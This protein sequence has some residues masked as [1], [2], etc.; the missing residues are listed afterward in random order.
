MVF[1]MWEM[2]LSSPA[3]IAI[4]G[5]AA[6]GGKSFALLMEPLRHVAKTGFSAVIFR[7]TSKQVKNEGGLWDASS[8][9]Y[10]AIGGK[11]KESELSWQDLEVG[12]IVQN[13][14][15]Y[16][17]S[18][19]LATVVRGMIDQKKFGEIVKLKSDQII[20]AQTIGYPK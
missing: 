16:C 6:G 3:D 17:A 18:E 2:F 4:Y 20:V 9:L 11:A 1:I 12:C 14:Y 13:V 15:L 5:G 8:G 10:G 7:R 19:G